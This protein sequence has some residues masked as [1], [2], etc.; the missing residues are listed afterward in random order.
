MGEAKRRQKAWRQPSPDS[1][2]EILPPDEAAERMM[3][4]PSS[5]YLPVI[6][7]CKW[8]GLT[9]EQF[10]REAAAGRITVQGI[11]RGGGTYSDLT[12]TAHDACMWLATRLT[13][14]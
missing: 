5:V 13:T 11:N 9:L 4:D 8:A 10:K 2:L 6:E 14:H 7:F 12:V 1:G 3:E